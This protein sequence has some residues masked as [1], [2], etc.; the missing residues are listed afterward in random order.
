MSFWTWTFP[1]FNFPLCLSK[2]WF[3]NFVSSFPLCK[4]EEFT[5]CL[6][7]FHS[8]VCYVLKI[9]TTIYE[10]CVFTSE[11]EKFFSVC[12]QRSVVSTW[13]SLFRGES[14]RIISGT[15]GQILLSLALWK[16]KKIPWIHWNFCGLFFHLPSHGYR[17]PGNHSSCSCLLPIIEQSMGLPSWLNMIRYFKEMKQCQNPGQIG[18]LLYFFVFI[19][20]IF[21]NKMLWYVI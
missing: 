5:F 18:I 19:I 4:R 6:F 13:T 17:K 11:V 21:C 10:L 3:L 16:K 20:R 8:C 2:S 7:F 12:V 15:K 9:T 1:V 14:L